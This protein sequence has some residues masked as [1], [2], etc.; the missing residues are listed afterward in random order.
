MT[1]S[2]GLGEPSWP[3]QGDSAHISHLTLP[4]RSSIHYLDLLCLEKHV[5]KFVFSNRIRIH[6]LSTIELPV[7][8]A[9]NSYMYVSSYV[10]DMILPVLIDKSTPMYMPLEL[11]G[12]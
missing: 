11:N 4:Y 7:S 9:Y 3:T 1:N 10:L 2:L 8:P 12:L 5:L 6:I